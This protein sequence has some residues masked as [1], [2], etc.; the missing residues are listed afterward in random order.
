M[1][2]SIRYLANRQMNP[3]FYATIEAVEESIQNAMTAAE[4]IVGQ[5]GRTVHALPL[6]RLQGLLAGKRIL[7]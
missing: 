3:F 4:T 7:G 5:K 1:P 2:T 6:D